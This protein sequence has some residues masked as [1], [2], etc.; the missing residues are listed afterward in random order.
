MYISSNRNAVKCTTLYKTAA[1]HRLQTQL[2]EDYVGLMDQHHS[3]TQ[4]NYN[5]ELSSF[6]QW[7]IILIVTNMY[8]ILI[9]LVFRLGFH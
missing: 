6:G 9:Y 3:L 2:T 8:R 5:I 7:E 1:H 4:T